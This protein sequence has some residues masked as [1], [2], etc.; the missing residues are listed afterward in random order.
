LNPLSTQKFDSAATGFFRE[1]P[2]PRELGLSDKT[3]IRFDDLKDEQLDQLFK[4]QA[5]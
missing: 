4:N 3:W 2:I 5:P 1:N